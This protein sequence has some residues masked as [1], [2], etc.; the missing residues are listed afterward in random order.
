MNKNNI[1]GSLVL[2]LA[3]VIWGF[4]FVAQDMVNEAGVEPF[5]LNAIR[6]YIGCFFLIPVTAFLSKKKGITL[7]PSQKK[8]RKKLIIAGIVCGT[9]LCVA[10]NLQQFGIAAYPAGVAVSARAGFLT[11]MYILMVPIFGIFMKKSP[12]ITVWIGVAVAVV[13]LY[14]LC[15][16]DKISGIY[17]GDVVML[18]CA[19]AFSMHIIF[20]D[21]F[22]EKSVD[23]V[24]LSC[25]QFFV[26][27]TLSTILM[28]V[29]EK[30]DINNILDAALPI[31]F[32]GIMSSGIA[33]T[34]QIIGQNICENPTVASIS[35]S[36]ESV[37]GAVGGAIF[38][39]IMDNREITGC[40][41]MFAAVILA[42]LPSPFKNKR[43]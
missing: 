40:V 26:C 27:A 4:T 15:F 5:T 19:V 25:V 16:S 33:Y 12:E 30:P 29:F 43:V 41:I 37:F 31:L 9:C 32:A 34:L 18:L 10:A 22:L 35:M 23:G 21:K 13:G 8:D 42:Q 28:F 17:F 7:I 20:V 24:K 1:K 14:L 11:A 2:L 3:A 6:S 36:F 39:D 38:G